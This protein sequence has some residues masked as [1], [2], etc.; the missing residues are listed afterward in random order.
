MRIPD[1]TTK[2]TAFAQQLQATA[3]TAD[4]P[5]ES[6]LPFP[7]QKRLTPGTRRTYRNR[8]N[9]GELL[10]TGFEGRIHDGYL[11]ARVRP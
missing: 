4:D 11:Y 7:N 8:I 9:N 6:W 5:N 2:Y 3:T 10:G 1:R